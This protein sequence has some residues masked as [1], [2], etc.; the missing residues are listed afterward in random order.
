LNL[1]TPTRVETAKNDGKIELSLDIGI[2]NMQSN[3]VDEYNGCD[4]AETTIG[5]RKETEQQLDISIGMNYG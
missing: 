1:H 5:K 3:R 4:I 2:Q